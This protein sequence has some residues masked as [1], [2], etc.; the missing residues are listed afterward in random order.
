MTFLAP[1]LFCDDDQWHDY[2]ALQSISGLRVIETGFRWKP[3][4]NFPGK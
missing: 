4:S 1:P 2:E 3:V